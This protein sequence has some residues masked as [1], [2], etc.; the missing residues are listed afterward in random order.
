MRLCLFLGGVKSLDWIGLTLNFG[1]GR[2][3]IAAGSPVPDEVMRRLVNK[4]NLTD[5]TIT[6]GFV[7]PLTRCLN[8][9]TD[10]VVGF[11]GKLKRPPR[12]SC[13]Q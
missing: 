13:R 10:D 9:I 4:M 11:S 8:K 6:Y 5:L 1:I 12:R 3:G 7:F 2:T